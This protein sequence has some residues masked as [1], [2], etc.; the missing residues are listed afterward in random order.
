MFQPP[1][2]SCLCPTA[3]RREFI[4]QM[5]RCFTQQ[6]YPKIELIVLDDGDDKIGDLIPLDDRQQFSQ[7]P[8]IRY[9]Y[10]LPK[11]NHGQKMN[12]CME[13][14]SGEYCIVVDDDDWYAPN[15]ISRQI[16]PLLDNPQ[17]QVSGT[18]QLYYRLHGANKA[19]RYVNLTD[20]K[21]I[22]AIAFRRSAWENNRFEERGFGADFYFINKIPYD[23]WCDLNDL[24]LMVSTIHAA[25]AAP[26]CIPSPSFVE[27]PWETVTAIIEG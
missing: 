22:G 6:D 10:E 7:L 27:V 25:N 8:R 24:T 4:P 5:L 20:K 18:G 21:W 26:K 9:F 14:A 11:K 12:R 16:Q 3:N 1:L 17:I 19:F 2:V 13:L 15:R 23:Q